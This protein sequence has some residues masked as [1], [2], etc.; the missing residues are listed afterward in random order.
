MIMSVKLLKSFSDGFLD[1]MVF[2]RL[3]KV[4][5]LSPEDKIDF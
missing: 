4:L 5:T 1:I 3:V 2:K